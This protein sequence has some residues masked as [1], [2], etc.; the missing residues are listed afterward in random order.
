MG[1]AKTTIS[2]SWCP[3]TRLRRCDGSPQSPPR[4]AQRPSGPFENGLK[5]S[6]AT[7]DL[8]TEEVQN[9]GCSVTA[10][11]DGEVTLLAHDQQTFLLFVSDVTMRRLGVM[12][13]GGSF[14]CMN[15]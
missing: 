11:R 15:P 5:F 12:R 2:S 6:R 8:V 7:A 13:W 10:A 3:P 4:F 14:G 9:L 1:E